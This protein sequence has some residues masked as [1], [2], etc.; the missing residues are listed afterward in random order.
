MNTSKPNENKLVSVKTGQKVQISLPKLCNYGDDDDDESDEEISKPKSTLKNL[1]P[2]VVEVP[3]E[4][5]RSGLLGLLPPPKSSQNPFIKTT[6]AAQTSSFTESKFNKSTAPAVKE[7]SSSSSSSSSLLL[8][9]TM[10]S[11]TPIKIADLENEFPKTSKKQIP[12]PVSLDP[13]D[14]PEPFRN[15]QDEDD[16]D[17]EGEDQP[18]TSSNYVQTSSISQQILDKE[19]MLR[20]C[21]SQGNKR[22]LEDFE[23]TDISAKQLVGDNKAELLKQVTDEYKPATNKE[24]FTTSSRKTHHVTYLAKVAIERDQELRASWAANKFNKRMAREK[25][26][27]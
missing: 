6:P 5:P 8:P 21:G 10:A 13:E 3:K 27:F 16:N 12:Q 7:T 18:E 14:D 19:A 4:K 24:Y 2:D 9:R 26:G 25:Y 17:D 15:E 11:K 1:K 20:L 23:I 22:K